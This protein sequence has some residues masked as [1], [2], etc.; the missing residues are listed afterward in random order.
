M[1]CNAHLLQKHQE[2]D[3]VAQ[4]GG[5][6]GLAGDQVE[7]SGGLGGALL[8]P[9][10]VLRDHSRRAVVRDHLPVTE[11]SVINRCVKPNPSE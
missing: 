3:V 8:P 10:R 5:Q 4:R 6:R 11:G 7:A 9:G 1:N 2:G